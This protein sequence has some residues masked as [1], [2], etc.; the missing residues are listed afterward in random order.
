MTIW[1]KVRCCAEIIILIYSWL[2]ASRSQGCGSDRPLLDPDPVR[3]KKTGSGP[4]HSPLN[5]FSIN[6]LW[7]KSLQIRMFRAILG[8]IFENSIQSFEFF[9]RLIMIFY[10]E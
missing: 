6:L 5:F 9:L 8:I 4:I 10:L 3:K 1:G 2:E 7:L